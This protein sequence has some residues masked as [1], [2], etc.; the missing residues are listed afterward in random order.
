MDSGCQFR[1]PLTGNCVLF[2]TQYNKYHILRDNISNEVI[3]QY[4]GN[5]TIPITCHI[6]RHK[7]DGATNPDTTNGIETGQEEYGGKYSVKFSWYVSGSPGNQVFYIDNKKVNFQ[8]ISGERDNV[9]LADEYCTKGIVNALL[10][11][12]GALIP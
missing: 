11:L 7:L 2:W 4:A 8:F 12:D 9:E 3:G 10:S 5:A 1:N 6:V